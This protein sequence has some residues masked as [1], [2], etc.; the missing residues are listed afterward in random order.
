MPPESDPPPAHVGQI[1]G[2]VSSGIK[3][4]R[5]GR[6]PVLDGVRG[7]AIILVLLN[8]LAL[9]W[10]GGAGAV[11][12]TV[13]FVLSGF[14][15]TALL[16]EER[17]STGTIRLAAFYERRA[18]RLLPA[19]VVSTAAVA[20][21]G[22]AL[23]PRWFEW[24]DLPPVLLYYGN[25]VQAQVLP[26]GDLGSLASTWSLAVEEQFYLVWPLILLVVARAGRRAVLLFAV[27][28]AWCSL[29]LR[30]TMIAS[31]PSQPRLYFGSDVVAFALLV[32]AALVAW[33]GSRP[34]RPPARVLVPVA[35]G[36]IAVP[37]AFDS[38][39]AALVA[40]PLSALGTA[41]LL[42]G[43]SSGS[44]SVFEWS[45]LRWFGTRSYSIYLWHAPI[46]IYLN[47][48]LGWEGPRL[49]AA[50]LGPPLA[51]AEL[52]YRCVE[53]PLR[54]RRADGRDHQLQREPAARLTK[55][56]AINT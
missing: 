33:L 8:H 14:L 22:S 56:S 37:C 10:T 15:I 36:L 13:F 9:P 40:L 46:A 29:W 43:L 45:V 6:R 1:D 27:V 49:W 19:L 55:G 16:L 47:Q 3:T 17:E 12:V 25:W 30:L 52:S 41:L 32:G 26:G 23:G 48:T 53:M 38:F 20:S 44:H 24:R 7:L 28:G 31:S 39:T 50:V 21:L 11:G 42:L 4:W 18:R 5:L 35:V 34:E 51:L 54:R 2:V